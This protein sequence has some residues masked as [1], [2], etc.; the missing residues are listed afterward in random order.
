MSRIGVTTRRIATRSRLSEK[1]RC[2]LSARL[3]DHV[4]L[5]VVDVVVDPGEDRHERR[6]DGVEDL[7]DEELLAA[8]RLIAVAL[9]QLR[10][11]RERRRWIVTT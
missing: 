10:Q 11:G 6:D 2:R 8:D 9:A 4:L 7:V 5:D 3:V 1:I